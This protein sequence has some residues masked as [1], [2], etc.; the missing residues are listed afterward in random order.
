[1]PVRPYSRRYVEDVETGRLYRRASLVFRVETPIGEFT[2]TTWNWVENWTAMAGDWYESPPSEVVE[3]V[4]RA[5]EEWLL[6]RGVSITFALEFSYRGGHKKNWITTYSYF[7]VVKPMSEIPDHTRYTEVRS[8]EMV[9]V[10]PGTHGLRYPGV[11][12]R[13]ER[14]DVGALEEDVRD[15]IDEVIGDIRDVLVS[16]HIERVV[17]MSPPLAE[18]CEGEGEIPE[19]TVD[20]TF[21]AE[22]V[23]GARYERLRTGLYHPGRGEMRG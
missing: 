15:R 21:V 5:V 3:Q 17:E 11:A 8:A 20:V 16:E 19:E 12:V 23:T 10:L 18:T 6:T 14:I 4:I 2:A 13:P 1:M 7:R 9:D 22:R